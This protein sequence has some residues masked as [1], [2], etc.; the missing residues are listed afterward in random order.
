MK[1]KLKEEE[2]FWL[3][4]FH[5]FSS[6]DSWHLPFCA[7]IL[8]LWDLYFWVCVFKMLFLDQLK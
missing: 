3:W 7:A 8:L 5:K 2:L 4:Y 1:L 6:T